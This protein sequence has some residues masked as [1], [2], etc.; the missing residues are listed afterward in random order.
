LGFTGTGIATK[1][2]TRKQSVTCILFWLTAMQA[3]FGLI[4]AGYDGDIALPNAHN[5]PWVIL[6]GLAG[7][8]AHFCITRALQLAPAVV[9]YPM[10]FVRLPLAAVIGILFYNEPFQVLVFLGAAI[11]LGANFFN[12]RSEHR[13]TATG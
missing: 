2:L 8:F 4:A 1:L 6:I 10:D 12:I 13:Q 3:V 11:I 5:W 7:L 9:V